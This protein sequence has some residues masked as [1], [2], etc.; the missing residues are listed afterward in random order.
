[1]GA[2]DSL[3][4]TQNQREIWWFPSQSVAQD[5]Y[6]IWNVCSSLMSNQEAIWAD[7]CV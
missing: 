1:M 2:S 3:N 4:E 5:V 7:S 6:E